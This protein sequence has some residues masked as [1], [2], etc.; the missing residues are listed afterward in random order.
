MAYVSTAELKTYLRNELGTL[1]DT[2][3]ASVVDAATTSVN[4]ACQRSFDVAGAGSARVYVPN[5]SDTLRIHD[6]TT[7]TAVTE[8]GVTLDSTAYQKEPL[9]ALDW[10]GE[11]RPYEQLVRTDGSVWVVAVENKASVSVTATWGWSAIPAGVKQAC[12]IMAAEIARQR[13]VRFGVIDAGDAAGA[14]VLSNRKVRELLE[15]HRRP[16]ALGLPV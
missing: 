1:D 14:I 13:D 15:R 8:D 3:L 12:W 16:E 5:G 10:T 2:F 9:N 7:V 4:Q 11:A 6:C